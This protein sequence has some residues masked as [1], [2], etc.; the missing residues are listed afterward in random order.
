[1]RAV[2]CPFLQYNRRSNGMLSVL[3]SCLRAAESAARDLEFR[4]RAPSG[5]SDVSILRE[6]LASAS[7]GSKPDCRY[8]PWREKDRPLAQACG[9]HTNCKDD[10]AT[11]AGAAR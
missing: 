10:R 5:K 1:M 4:S 6:K 2:I 7:K 8:R 9:C 11:S 3:L